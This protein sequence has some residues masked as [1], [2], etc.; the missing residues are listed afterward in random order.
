[1]S[2]SCPRS[3]EIS[4]PKIGSGGSLTREQRTVSD[5]NPIQ[6]LLTERGKARA[7]AEEQ[8]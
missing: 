7:T 3:N 6:K 4:E 1:M 5:H 8:K 2:Y